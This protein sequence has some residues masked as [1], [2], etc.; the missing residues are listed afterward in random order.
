[1]L[2]HSPDGGVGTCLVQPILVHVLSPDNDL[3]QVEVWLEVE[4]TWDQQE[5]ELVPESDGFNDQ[6]VKFVK[7]QEKPLPFCEVGLV[8]KPSQFPL[9]FISDVRNNDLKDDGEQLSRPPIIT[10]AKLAL[11]FST[12]PDLRQHRSLEAKEVL[13]VVRRVS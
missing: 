10:Q 2:Q 9:E 3:E 5:R 6:I 4:V 11:A 12:L 13:R 7:F 1:M 8:S